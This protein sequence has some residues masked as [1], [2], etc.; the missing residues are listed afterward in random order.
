MMVLDFLAWIDKRL[1][2]INKICTMDTLLS[3]RMKTCHLKIC[4]SH[5]VII[6]GCDV[7]NTA[8]HLAISS[9]QFLTV[10]LLKSV[11]GI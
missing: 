11:L 2:F 3:W 4:Q 5:R 7:K 9:A 8:G 1:T 10:S 6:V